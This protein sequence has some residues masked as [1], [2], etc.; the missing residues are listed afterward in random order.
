MDSFDAEN[1]KQL[2][3][4]FSTTRNTQKQRQSNEATCTSWLRDIDLDA[5]PEQSMSLLSS[6]QHKLS[7]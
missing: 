3:F 4:N 2:Y 6:K 1:R 7:Q 5:T